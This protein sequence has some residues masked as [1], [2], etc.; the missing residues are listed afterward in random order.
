MV[1]NH[2]VGVYV[3][4]SLKDGQV[5]KGWLRGELP[6]GVLLA[7]DP[8]GKDIR[9]I[10]DY[11]G[12]S[13]DWREKRA[14]FAIPD[15]ENLDNK[16]RKLDD[17]LRGPLER[18]F[19]RIDYRAL[20]RFTRRAPELTRDIE[21]YSRHSSRMFPE[22]DSPRGQL[23]D[24]V[25]ARVDESIDLH[26][27]VFQEFEQSELAGTV[28][29]F[30]AELSKLPADQALPYVDREF[31]GGSSSSLEGGRGPV[32]DRPWTLERHRI[33]LR[34]TREVR[35]RLVTAAL[36]PTHEGDEALAKDEKP[37]RGR[38]W[39]WGGASLRILAG[40]GLAVANGALGLTAGLATTITSVG[41]TAVPIYVGVATSIYYGVTQAADGLEKIGGIMDE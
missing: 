3:T 25:L 23:A 39:R 5:L 16:L 28:S 12:M 36:A 8:D 11:S 22:Y 19:S 35:T 2:G 41:A 26:E 20:K 1:S 6:N 10:E 30:G 15:G 31:I 7:V 24:F 27:E 4:V 40:T 29:Q 34:R 21:E 37:K 17:G 9:L 32:S 33:A 14:T 38:F 13:Y 18:S